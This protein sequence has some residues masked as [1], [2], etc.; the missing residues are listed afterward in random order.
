MKTLRTYVGV[1]LILVI[2]ICAVF[3]VHRL[4]RGASVDLTENNLYT[5]SQGSRN[6]IRKLNQ[7]I[8]LKLYYARTAALSGPEQIR[9]YNNY[10]RYVRD[11]LREYERVA[12]GKIDLEVIDPRPFSD[13]EQDATEAG[14]KS[15][16]LSA[17]EN[18]YFG[19]V[20]RTE[21]GKEKVIPFFQPDRQKFVEYD[22]SRLL[23][24]V[25]RR[26]KKKIGVLS[27]LPITGG[28]M[29]PY[30]RRMMQMQGR[31]VPE[32]WTIIKNLRERY[33]V[34]DVDKETEG[35][36]PDLDFLMVVHPKDLPEKTL[37]AIDQF[38]MRGGQ[39]LVFVDPHCLNDQPQQN[40]QNPM[41]G[42]Q[43]DASSNLNPLLAKW[44]VR[45]RDQ[46]IAADVNLAVQTRL[47]RNAPAQRLPVY[48]DLG[49]QAMNQ[50]EV[51]TG[52]LGSVR[53][54]FG[55][56][57]E[58]E[59]DAGTEVVP[60]LHTTEEGRLWKP[61]SPYELRM[62]DPRRIRASL[63]GQIKEHILGARI[64]G[65]FETNFPDG[66]PEE[67]KEDAE[68]NGGEGDEAT[69]GAEAEEET[70]AAEAEEVP[71]QL[72]TSTSEASVLV[73]S[74]VDMISDMLA[75]RQGFLGMSSEAGDNAAL[76]MNSV[77][78]LSGN[79]DLIQVRSRGRFKRPFTVVQNIEAQT[80][81]ATAEKI[82][83]LNEK[84]QSYR[85][86]LWQ[87]EDT[88]EDAERLQSE[89]VQKRQELQKE[90]RKARRELRELNAGK[91]ERIESLKASLQF[92]NLVWAPAGVLLIAIV[93]SLV[94]YFKAR[95]YAARR[96]GE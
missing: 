49:Q 59:D 53:M 56:V 82:D 11:L 83:A 92:H 79:R 7:P 19:L 50:Q 84:I 75:Y 91:R 48:L 20:A 14:L 65:T 90:I 87:L 45:L 33:E 95:Y 57:L 43:H 44:G 28:G 77:E 54:L 37:F 34:V 55:G 60:L 89:T 9:H 31:Q 38:V 70:E 27:S 94:R 4:S 51:V 21:L 1:V 72:R 80:E 88:G 35:I 96:R 32:Q 71:P 42:M 64:T 29:S 76:V 15:V 73:F 41:A 86:E 12:R 74:D 5:L 25:T 69:E 61:Q 24:N 2:S 39:L 16:P 68:G 8:D 10:F 62:P 46:A 85:R 63:T 6:I 36:E 18:F 22:I 81:E 17:D 3:V 52:Q 30:M 93:L 47:Q 40:P 26:E 78:F 23:V 67:E 66:P 58:V 13:E